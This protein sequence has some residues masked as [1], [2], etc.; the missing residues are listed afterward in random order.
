MRPRGI[1][2]LTGTFLNLFGDIRGGRECRLVTDVVKFVVSNLHLNDTDIRAGSAQTGTD[3][4]TEREQHM[5][6][7]VRIRHIKRYCQ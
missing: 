3:C 4:L 2:K 7:S 6:S 1:I 5:L